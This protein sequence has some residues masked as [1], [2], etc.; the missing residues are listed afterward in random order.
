MGGERGK[1]G[2]RK[3]VG[4]RKQGGGLSSR[5]V[6]A[7][8]RVNSGPRREYMIDICLFKMIC[9]KQATSSAWRLTNGIGTECL[10]KSKFSSR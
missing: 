10:R 7:S 8:N 5:D 6:R 9:L 1:W 4:G 2:G 3:Q